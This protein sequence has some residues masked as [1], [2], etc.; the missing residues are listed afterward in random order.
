MNQNPIEAI[1]QL[2]K[3]QYYDGNRPTYN[4]SH[5][6]GIY[7][8]EIQKL[9]SSSGNHVKRYLEQAARKV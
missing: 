3:R 8:N 5:G 9:C 1:E 2:I 7:L 4:E 6:C